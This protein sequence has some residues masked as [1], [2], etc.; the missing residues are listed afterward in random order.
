MSVDTW[1]TVLR[2]NGF[3]GVDVCCHDSE[4]A[5]DQQLS[6]MIAGQEQENDK[7]PL[8]EGVIILEPPETS[9]ELGTV[10]SEIC[11]ILSAKDISSKSIPWTSDLTLC[12]GKNVIALMEMESPFLTSL[13]EQ[14]FLSFKQL[15]NEAASVL[16]AVR[17]EDPA[18][19]LIFG[20]TR[21]MR[22]E[23]PDLKFKVLHLKDVLKISASS[24]AKPICDVATA[25]G[26]EPEF[27]FKDDIL[28]IGRYVEEKSMN[29]MIAGQSRKAQ[30]GPI[31]IGQSLPPL[32]LEI[33]MP[34]MLD[35]LYFSED[36]KSAE[37][38]ESDEV[39]F[40]VKASG[41]K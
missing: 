24:L 36:T 22:S 13:T 16:W 35:T 29:E 18:M 6:L 32:K 7:S 5:K 2:R 38:L 28:S 34:G 41:L 15:V 14:D 31:S 26:P 39:E 12:H 4:I 30:P 3:N 1:D 33:G 25:I 17:G 23:M 8:A 21:T 19:E 20:M 10:S 9:Q 37:N 11:G 40:E 27:V